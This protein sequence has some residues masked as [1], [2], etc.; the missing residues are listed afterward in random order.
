MFLKTSF[1]DTL[2]KIYHRVSERA[3]YLS[4]MPLNLVSYNLSIYKNKTSAQPIF[5]TQSPQDK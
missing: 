5:I 1:K 2:L 4:C 3:T